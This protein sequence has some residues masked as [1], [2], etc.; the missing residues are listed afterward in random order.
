MSRGFSW[1]L[2]NTNKIWLP[3]WWGDPIVSP[4]VLSISRTIS[5][6]TTTDWGS[7]TALELK[8]ASSVGR[9]CRT[10]PPTSTPRARPGSLR[11]PS[12]RPVESGGEGGAITI[13][14]KKAP[15]P[16]W[17]V[18]RAVHFGRGK[19]WAEKSGKGPKRGP[20]T[21]E[22]GQVVGSPRARAS[23]GGAS[24]RARRQRLGCKSIPAPPSPSRPA[25][26]SAAAHASCALRRPSARLYLSGA[27]AATQHSPGA[28]RRGGRS[29]PRL[30]GVHGGAL[31]PLGA[32][33]LSAAAGARD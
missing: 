3:L 32:V 33:R 2:L 29:A 21:G 28:R 4:D 11:P 26:G 27:G 23:L 10:R 31:A 19:S 24:G 6:N 20:G 9:R 14:P 12:R 15:L 1:L 18:P 22:G 30:S 7:A 25:R 8:A 5:S 16:K 13:P 17:P